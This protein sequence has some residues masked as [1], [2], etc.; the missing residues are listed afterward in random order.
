MKKEMCVNEVTE[1]IM[2]GYLIF[3]FGSLIPIVGNYFLFV[4]TPYLFVFPVFFSVFSMYYVRGLVILNIVSVI[5]WFCGIYLMIREGLLTGIYSEV[6]WIL[7]MSICII[8]AGI[9]WTLF[10]WNLSLTP[11][12]QVMVIMIFVMNYRTGVISLGILQIV[13]GFCFLGKSNLVYQELHPKK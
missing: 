8:L 5:S 9:G 12:E 1:Q 13:L 6:K 2:R 3:F 7:L 10:F 4:L 11:L